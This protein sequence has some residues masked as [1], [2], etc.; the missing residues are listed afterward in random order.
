MSDGEGTKDVKPRRAKGET[1]EDAEGSNPATSKRANFSKKRSSSV[2]DIK[3]TKLAERPTKALFDD[4]MLGARRPSKKDGDS[5]KGSDSAK[6]TDSDANSGSLKPSS[7]KSKLKETEKKQDSDDESSGKAVK[8]SSTKKAASRSASSKELKAGAI[9]KKS[10]ASSGSKDKMDSAREKKSSKAVELADDSVK[11]SHSAGDIKS[12]RDKPKDKK[13]KE[14]SKSKRTKNSEEESSGMTK[15]SSSESLKQSDSSNSLHVGKP[16]VSVPTLDTTPEIAEPTAEIPAPITPKDVAAAPIPKAITPRADDV[17]LPAP[18]TPRAGDTPDAASSSVA[19]GVAPAPILIVDSSPSTP[20]RTTDDDS[21]SESD[22]V[23]PIKPE[24]EKPG[25]PAINITVK[26]GKKTGK[27]S[28]STKTRRAS[29]TMRMTKSPSRGATDAPAAGSLDTD[30]IPKTPTKDDS[31]LPSPVSVEATSPA[32]ALAQHPVL[33]RTMSRGNSPSL[34]PIMTTAATPPAS[35]RVSVSTPRTE[36]PPPPPSDPS[37]P[38][39]PPPPAPGMR[40]INKKELLEVSERKILTRLNNPRVDAEL[41]KWDRRASGYE[42]TMQTE[43]IQTDYLSD[44]LFF[45]HDDVFVEVT[46]PLIGRLPDVD[47]ETPKSVR[48]CMAFFAQPRKV[49]KYRSLKYGGRVSLKERIRLRD[50]ERAKLRAAEAAAA[51][52]TPAASPNMESE[53]KKSAVDK[54]KHEKKKP[55]MSVSSPRPP[56]VP[57]PEAVKPPVASTNTALMVDHP[58]SA[59]YTGSQPSSPAPKNLAQMKLEASTPRNERNRSASVGFESADDSASA[60]VLLEDLLTLN[61]QTVLKSRL[62]RERSIKGVFEVLNPSLASTEP[63]ETR[64]EGRPIT[65]EY[66]TRVLLSMQSVHIGVGCEEA[67]FFSAAFYDF[68]KRLRLTEDFHFDFNETNDLIHTLLS[69]QQPN[70]DAESKA[71]RGLFNLSYTSSNVHLVVRVNGLLRG[72]IDEVLDPYTPGNQLS[73][74]EKQKLI[75]Q[76]RTATSIMYKYQQAYAWTAVRLK[77][78]DSFQFAWPG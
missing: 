51:A 74:K 76:G 23:K 49:I 44:M 8:E 60:Y 32:A 17:P 47:G 38:P 57:I 35:P 39:P 9:E 54:K 59:S 75:D 78:I 62:E 48:D 61:E 55:S 70:Q 16:A 22:K 37:A 28:P 45:P 56:A 73:A 15:D 21:D 63:T 29:Q 52:S 26:R 11:Q 71:K 13:E 19:V 33:R 6:R 4:S 41:K 18:I 27:D 2:K 5:T 20:K 66:G 43:R 77:T 7:S 65:R 50:E 25:E 72:A 12:P 36:T 3:S 34:P 24:E 64:T 30:S 58:L 40:R 68:E 42:Q 14:K 67:F 1:A 31:P 10:P 69:A 53:R 46:K